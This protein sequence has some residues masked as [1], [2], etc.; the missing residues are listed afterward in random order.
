MGRSEDR[1]ERDERSSRSSARGQ[2]SGS[3]KRQDPGVGSR[4]KD[5]GAQWKRDSQKSKD[6]SALSLRRKERERER[7]REEGEDEDEDDD[8][9]DD[10]EEDRRY[11]GRGQ[12]HV[13]PELSQ[14]LG[15]RRSE[16][17][18]NVQSID[19]LGDLDADEAIEIE[20]VPENGDDDDNDDEQDAHDETPKSMAKSEVFGNVMGIGD[21]M[22]M[23]EEVVEEEEEEEEQEE[24]ERRVSAS[25]LRAKDTRKPTEV[26]GG[27]GP[28]TGPSPSAASS[29]SASKRGARL[30]QYK[31]SPRVNTSIAESV[32]SVE[33]A[34]SVSP[35]PAN[36][37]KVGFLS[38]SDLGGV[39]GSDLGS[40]PPPP[41]PSLFLA[42]STPPS[43]VPTPIQPMLAHHDSNYSMD[44]DFEPLESPSIANANKKSP[45][46]VSF[47]TVG[48]AQDD[49]ES[50]LAA[51]A[52]LRAHVKRH[53]NSPGTA[54]RI[55]SALSAHGG[56]IGSAGV[57][58]EVLSALGFRFRSS[59][60]SKG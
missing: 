58:E 48:S 3:L 57:L 52:R 49:D 13:R 50:V 41:P 54:K 43:H 33:S 60:A 40:S 24:E 5:A 17:Y 21:L 1:D 51:V 38:P 34:V 36:R 42:L 37:G 9:N 14:T 6:L 32:G 59:A 56:K 7:Q 45:R 8:A 15:P 26:G 11:G 10:D 18:G 28:A 2:L 53:H 46:G 39:L 4:L 47:A 19:A 12:G 55:A 23:D 30:I 44:E 25:S 27:G 29:S 16:V 22:M 35:D 31:A 20:E